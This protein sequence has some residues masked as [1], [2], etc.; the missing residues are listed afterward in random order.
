[1]SRVH[2]IGIEAIRKSSQITIEIARV[3]EI[4]RIGDGGFT[5]EITGYS[6]YLPGLINVIF[7]CKEYLHGR[8]LEKEFSVR[9]RK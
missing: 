2:V 4:A 9:K 5:N 6:P 8:L 3:T 1:M 7:L